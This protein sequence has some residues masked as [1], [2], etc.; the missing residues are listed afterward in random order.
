[1]FRNVFG[2]GMLFYWTL[3]GLGLNAG[4]RSLFRILNEMSPNFFTVVIIIGYIAAAVLCIVLDAPLI[5][6]SNRAGML[7]CFLTMDAVDDIRVGFIAL[8]QFPIIFLFATKNSILSLLLG[9]GNGYERLNFIHQWS[10]RIMFLGA[11]LHGA[12]WI[13]NHLEYGIEIIGQQKETSGIAAFGALGVIILSSLRPIRRLCYEVF[14]IIQCVAS[15]PPIYAN[16]HLLLACFHSS[17]SSSQFAIIQSMPLLG[18]SPLWHCTVW[19]Y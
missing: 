6:N 11:V 14:Y 4:Q 18:Y 15:F 10:G 12:L 13:R 16:P 17:L 1:M 2:E 5:S 8:A 7:H 19:I 9:P 3:P